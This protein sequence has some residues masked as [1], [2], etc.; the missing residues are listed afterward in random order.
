MFSKDDADL[1]MEWL[2]T[3]GVAVVAVLLGWHGMWPLSLCFTLIGSAL[4]VVLLAHTRDQTRA[5]SRSDAAP[6]PRSAGRLKLF[7]RRR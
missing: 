1:T 2:T 7:S 5:G 6:I 3:I 4:F